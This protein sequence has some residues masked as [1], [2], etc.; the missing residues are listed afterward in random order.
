MR[1]VADGPDIPDE[2]LVSRDNGDVVLFCGAG[3]SVGYAKLPG[4]AELGK[5]VITILGAAQDSPARNLL[6]MATESREMPAVGGLVATDRVFGLLEREFEV[7][8]VRTAVAQAIK[9]APHA[10]LD[11]HHAL[12]ALATTRSGVPRVVTTNFDLLFEACDPDIK[13]SG[14][15]NLPDPRSDLDFRGVV[16]LHGR[17]D[18]AYTRAMDEEFVI[19]SADFGR[20]YLAEGWATRFI[21]ALLTRY[22]ILFVGY[23]ADDPP[24]Q[25]LLEGLNLAEGTRQR[26]YALQSGEE[27]TA[28]AL[29]K[30]RGVQ[31]IPF[32]TD[33]GFASLWET[34]H[35]WAERAQ[36]NRRWYASVLSRAGAGPQHLL[37][38]ERGQVVHLLSTIEGARTVASSPD[39]PDAA[40][41]LVGDPMQRYA[42]PPGSSLGD[43]DTFDAYQTLRLDCDPVPKLRDPKQVWQDRDV[44]PDAVDIFG[45]LLTDQGLVINQRRTAI[46][47][48]AGSFATDL[49]PRQWA[50]SNWFYR[51]A[52]APVA[53][54]WAAHQTN[55]HPN[56]WARVEAA[57]DHDGGRFTAEAVRMWRFIL[58]ARSVPRGHLDLGRYVIQQRGQREGW[59]QSVVRD[60]ADVYRPWVKVEPNKGAMRGLL[61]HAA[62]SLRDIIHVHVEHPDVD[63]AFEVPDEVV[64]YLVICERANL[65]LA[66]SLEEEVSGNDRLYLTTTRPLDG[67]GEFPNRAYGLSAT[68]IRFLRLINRLSILDRDAARDQIFSWPKR[69]NY[70]FARLRIWAASRQLLS[71]EEACRIFLELSDVA[72]WTSIHRRD[73]LFALRDRWAELNHRQRMALERRILSSAFPYAISSELLPQAIAS[74]R[75]DYLHWLSAHGVAF[76]LSLDAVFKELRIA[77][78]SWTPALGDAA[79]DSDAPRVFDVAADQM[80]GALHAV[81]LF[82][83]LERAKEIGRYDF[84]SHSERRPFVGLAQDRPVRALGALTLAAKVGQ[85][86]QWAWSAFLR[87]DA[88]AMDAARMA[89]ALAARLSTLPLSEL[90]QI[91]YP[92]S[93]WMDGLNA[94]VYAEE[95]AIMSLLWPRLVAALDERAPDKNPTPIRSW[96]DAALNSPVGRMIQVL[97]RDP[98]MRNAGAGSCFPRDWLARVEA[99]L[100]L[101]GASRRHALVFLG[102]QLRLLYSVDPAW[103]MQNLIP[104]I[105]DP[106]PDGDALWQ[107]IF[108]ANQLPQIEL[109]PLL[110]P[111][112]IAG[113]V[114]KRRRLEGA[115]LATFLL[116]GWGSASDTRAQ[117][118]SD[119]EMREVLIHAADDLRGSV[120]W[121]LKRWSLEPGGK[122]RER[123]VPF[124][125][126]VWPKQRALRSAAMSRH[127]A[128]LA[129]ASGDLMP[130][131]VKCIV[132]HLVPVENMLLPF[133]DSIDIPGKHPARLQPEAVLDIFW[134]LLSEEP[135]KW[136]TG[137]S[138]TLEI[139]LETPSTAS[140]PRLAEL[141]HRIELS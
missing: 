95:L 85:A 12:L 7:S 79:A 86:P 94:R 102:H 44:P 15:P 138:R 34:L 108:W 28:S 56:F 134:V 124:L 130:T 136:P 50:L 25:Y 128:E 38:H 129:F 104:A 98:V 97:F 60:L 43:D 6:R 107:G 33:R 103:T 96:A 51:I 21:Q 109:Y 70:L 24:V 17:V 23:S 1:F 80:P 3:V 137:T 82:E 101:A 125:D 76:T 9:P 68:L 19:S 36:D 31:A 119:E 113:A 69:D 20:A 55:I 48:E 135:R 54:W 126:K 93:E 5:R 117:L 16:H 91:A 99:L 14:P 123:I 35:A 53:L 75:L 39:I 67:E 115:S 8:D 105:D 71:P 90:A 111:A 131:V 110:K 41:L 63:T 40:W 132:P 29:W 45:P 65:N 64:G 57:L 47:G 52:H 74:D 122:W 120:L 100:A 42:T 37:P 127:L 4:F 62:D 92:V 13:S 139:L 81:P 27:E 84:A 58:A 89:R 72:F 106:G 32:S 121:Q 112:M 11:A 26:L 30:H 46:R 114:A 66:V 10:K 59:T 140:D 88:R 141:R 77:A 73:L 18:E 133:E 116:A 22:Q 118:V 2:L 61:E 49:S 87:M 83:I 78:P